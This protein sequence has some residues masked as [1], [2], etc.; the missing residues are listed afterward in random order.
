[1]SAALS[2]VALG[3]LI[4]WAVCMISGLVMGTPVSLM[5]GAVVGIAAVTLFQNSLVSGALLALLAPF[6][7]LLPAL[8]LRHMGAQLG[9]PVQPFATAE[10]VVILLVYV[11]FLAA[12]MG[13]IPVD[14]YRLGYAPIPVAIMV[15]VICAY[16]AASGSVFLPLVAV[17]GQGVWVMGWGSSNWFDEVTHATLVPI[18]VIVLLT[19]AV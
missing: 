9:L 1:M 7:I 13:V 5:L 16:G 19:R 3:I 17:L 18:L 2:S 8:A 11:G 10:L 4:T 15:L 12:A 14:I 6:G